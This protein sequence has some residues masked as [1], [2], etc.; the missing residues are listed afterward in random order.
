M[1]ADST[2]DGTVVTHTC[3]MHPEVVSSQPGECPKCGM[4]LVQK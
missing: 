3:P 1:P 4:N 2:T